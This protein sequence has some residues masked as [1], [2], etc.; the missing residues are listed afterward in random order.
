[1]YKNIVFPVDVSDEGSWK[2]ALPQAI[3]LV[4]S[5]NANLHI[6]TVVPDFGM[7]VVSQYFADDAEERMLKD[8]QNS[9]HEFVKAHVPEDIKVHHVISQGTVY[10]RIIQT[11]K[12]VDADLIVIAAHR[13]EL[14]DYLLGPNAAKVV[15]HSDISVLVVR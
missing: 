5:F 4:R 3:E 8:A 6:M 1:M 11:A 14:R 2:L 12:Q 13:P 10:R 7:S 9:L 15:R